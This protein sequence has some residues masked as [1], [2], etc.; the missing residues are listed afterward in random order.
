MINFKIKLN[1]KKD[2]PNCNITSIINSPV[3]INGKCIGIITNYYVNEDIATGCFFE[4]MI[5]NFSLDK[6]QIIS[7]ELI[8]GSLDF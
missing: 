8:K 7:M 3:L 2:Y 1:L 5:P 4:D 6:K